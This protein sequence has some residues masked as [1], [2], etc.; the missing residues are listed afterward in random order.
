MQI[1]AVSLYRS[2]PDRSV[3]IVLLLHCMTALTLLSYYMQGMQL[4]M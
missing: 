1:Y 3:Y 4:H 2:A